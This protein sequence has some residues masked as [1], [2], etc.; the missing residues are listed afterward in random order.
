MRHGPTTLRIP[1]RVWHLKRT[2]V[3]TVLLM[4][5]AGVGRISQGVYISQ[6]NVLLVVSTGHP[7]IVVLTFM[8]GRFGLPHLRAS[9]D[10]EDPRSI[11]IPNTAPNSREST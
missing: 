11:S 2:L 6:V 10:L 1:N 8:G 7:V 4:D 9:Y 3:A 5:E